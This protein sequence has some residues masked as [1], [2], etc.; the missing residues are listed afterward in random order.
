MVE[1]T[2]YLK[3]AQLL[4]CSFLLTKRM[5]VHDLNFIMASWHNVYSRFISLWKVWVLMKTVANFH[6]LLK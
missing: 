1:T 3:L 4:S 5:H 2:Q 6:L